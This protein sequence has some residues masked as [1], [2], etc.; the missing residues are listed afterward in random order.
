MVPRCK[1]GPTGDRSRDA[2]RR[3]GQREGQRARVDFRTASPSTSRRGPASA[4]PLILRPHP[5]ARQTSTEQET[6]TSV[7][8]AESCACIRR[9][10]RRNLHERAHCELQQRSRR[11]PLAS[12]PGAHRP[13][14]PPQ[15]I[16]GA[17]A[18]L[19]AE[20]AQRPARVAASQRRLPSRLARA[21][22][23]GCPDPAVLAQP[24]SA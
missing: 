17:R 8:C 11:R 7:S 22:R 18:H 10:E 14:F 23:S 4:S 2:Q 15:L 20:R 6:Y 13:R 21:A 16:V 24:C 3:A 9:R 1:A 12:E 19:P 5:T